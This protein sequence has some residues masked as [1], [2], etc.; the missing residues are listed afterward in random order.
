MINN[1]DKNSILIIGNGLTIDLIESFKLNYDSRR[2]FDW[3]IFYQPEFSDKRVKFFN[4]AI[5]MNNYISKHKKSIKGIEDYEIIEGF[6]NGLKS[7]PLEWSKAQ[8]RLYIQ[9]SNYFAIAYSHLQIDIDDVDITH[10]EYIEKF[11]KIKKSL[12]GIVSLNYDLLIERI[13]TLI[14]EKY[15]RIGMDKNYGGLPLFKPHGSI[16]FDKALGSMNLDI[17]KGSLCFFN[18]FPF[19]SLDK[20]KWLVP[21]AEADIV[22]PT[23]YPL[24]TNISWVRKGYN[25]IQNNFHNAKKCYIFGLSYW[26][27]DRPE[28]NYMIDLLDQ[29]CQ[30]IIVNPNPS[31]P[32]LVKLY[33]KFNDVKQINHL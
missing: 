27:C 20:D 29:N 7:H 16:D 10:W 19:K 25:W 26:S 17:E 22:L 6:L 32:M 28:L 18:D 11:N 21:R 15:Y 24:H 33:D 4:D 14:D 12:I 30:I 1:K 9:F 3:D 5:T 31:K 2:P 23:S 13:L 8:Q